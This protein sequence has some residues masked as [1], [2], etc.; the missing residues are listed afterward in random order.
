M[1]PEMTHSGE[2]LFATGDLRLGLLW[3]RSVGREAPPIPS[4]LYALCH[5]RLYPGWPP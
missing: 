4:N 5:F 1:K 2:R 3:Q